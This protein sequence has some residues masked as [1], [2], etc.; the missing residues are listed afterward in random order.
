MPPAAEETRLEGHRDG[1][2]PTRSCGSI[3]RFEDY[4]GLYAYHCHILEHEDHEMM[5]QFETR[6]ACPG[7]VDRNDAVD[8][9]DLIQVLDQWGPCPGCSA[10][11]N[12]DQQVDFNDLLV[13]L[14]RWGPCP[15]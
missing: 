10:D 11:I 1:R 14:D 6:P 4:T 7:D 13:V 12:G 3:A 8:F 9:Q 2:R 5:R 15:E